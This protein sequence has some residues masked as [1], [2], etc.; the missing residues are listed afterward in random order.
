M[1]EL[2]LP[3]AKEIQ[4]T[5]VLMVTPVALVNVVPLD[6]METRVI[7]V[8]L[9][10]LAPLAHLERL[11]QREKGEVLDHLA[12]LDRKETL[13]L[14]G[15]QELKESRGEEE[16]M[17]KRVIKGQM[18]LKGKRVK[19]GQRARGDFQVN[20]ETKEQRV[21][22]ACQAP[23][24]HQVYQ[25]RL[26]EM[27]PEVTLVMLDQ[28]EILDSLDQR[29]TLEDQVLAILG[30]E[31]HRVT[32]ERRAIVDLLAAEETVVKRVNL[33][34]KGHQESQVSQDPRVNLAKE[35]REESKGEMEIL[36][37]REI[38]ASLNVML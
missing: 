16:T 21:T 15:A 8:A 4:A 19:W 35:D 30:Q 14:L 5:E 18:D 38:L 33:E 22:M 11:D 7:Q 9:E 32:E 26:E 27:A 3:A 37:L 28:E 13:E 6:L 17:V 25:E 29:E 24:D 10:E 12:S 36:D 20:R 1:D 31:D 34:L 2:V 23:G